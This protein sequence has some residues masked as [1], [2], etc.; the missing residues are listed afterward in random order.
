MKQI[1]TYFMSTMM[2]LAFVVVLGLIAR[3]Y[4]LAFGFGWGL[5]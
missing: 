5:L 3:I 1:L 2:S 4:W